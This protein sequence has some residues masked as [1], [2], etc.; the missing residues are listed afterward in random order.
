MRSLSSAVASKVRDTKRL[1]Q[2][3]DAFKLHD[4]LQSVARGSH[5]IGV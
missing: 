2:R 5:V 1:E 3:V 4:A